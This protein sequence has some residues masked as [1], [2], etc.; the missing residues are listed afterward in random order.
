MKKPKPQPKPKPIS[1]KERRRREQNRKHWRK[2]C[3]AAW[4]YAE[5]FDPPPED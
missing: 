5:G 4:C 1:A 2:Q 3:F